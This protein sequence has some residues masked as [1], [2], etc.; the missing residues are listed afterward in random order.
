[1]MNNTYRPRH[2]RTKNEKTTTDT[3]GSSTSIEVN[4]SHEL[5]GYKPEMNGVNPMFLGLKDPYRNGPRKEIQCE[6][7]DSGKVLVA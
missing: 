2:S 4:V 7:R 5:W 3:T 1:M 6:S